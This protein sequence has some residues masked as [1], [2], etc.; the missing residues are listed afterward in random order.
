MGRF[1]TGLITGSVLAAVGVGVL[2]SDAKTRKRV[3]KDSR[4]AVRKAGDF[5]DGV[6][7]K[8]SM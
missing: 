6:T 7:E 4:R 1:S 3:V 5:F 2:M 8:M